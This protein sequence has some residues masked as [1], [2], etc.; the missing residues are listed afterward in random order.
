[1]IGGNVN[2]VHSVFSTFSAF[3]CNLERHVI[4]KD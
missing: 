3:F 1:M 4:F 2:V